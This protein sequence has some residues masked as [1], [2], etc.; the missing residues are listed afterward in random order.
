[1]THYGDGAEVSRLFLERVAAGTA[2]NLNRVLAA[3]RLRQFAS[4]EEVAPWRD[5][6]CTWPAR[7]RLEV[8]NAAAHILQ[9]AEWR[10]R[11]DAALADPDP[12]T[13]GIAAAAAE[14]IGLD[15]WPARLER[16]RSGE[17]QWYFLMRTDQ[18]ARVDMLLALANSQIDLG[19]IASGPGS[20]LGFGPEFADD[21]ALDWI[22]QDLGRFPGHGWALIEAGLKS[23]TTRGRN[24]A[25][26]A[27]AGWGRDRWPTGADRAL[28]AALAIEPDQRVSQVMQGVLDG[29]SYEGFA[30]IDDD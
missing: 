10:Q 14:A 16:Q 11:I 1:M 15:V 5:V 20:A 3:E 19:R 18:P 6:P 2:H 29:R 7:D 17:D 9:R 21:R 28:R 12:G 24:M 27:L 4:D 8:R 25:L 13:L 30:V 22:L 23:R 26:R